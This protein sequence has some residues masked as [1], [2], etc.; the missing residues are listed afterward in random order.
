[1][2]SQPHSTQP[3]GTSGVVLFA[4]A[5]ATIA[6]DQASMAR[7]NVQVHESP[8]QTRAFTSVYGNQNKTSKS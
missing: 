6:R 3:R 2:T 7:E 4:V 5:R 8:G 1:M